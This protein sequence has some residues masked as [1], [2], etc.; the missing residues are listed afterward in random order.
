MVPSLILTNANV[1]TL[2]PIQPRAQAVAISGSWITAVGSRGEI[3]DLADGAAVVDLGG[4]TVVPGFNDAHVH[5]LSHGLQL[6]RV[7]LDGAASLEEALARVARAATAAKPGAW[8]LGGRWN[9]NVWP[10]PEF[11]TRF[12]L[13]AVSGDHPVALRNKD[14]HSLWANSQALARAGITKTTEQ[15][16]GGEITRDPKNG[17]PAGILKETAI[18]LVERVIPPPDRAEIREALK[19]A[20]R[21]AS[22]AGLTSV[23]AIDPPDSLSVLQDLLQAGELDLRVNMMLPRDRLDDAI[24]LGIQTGFGGPL[25]RLGCVKFIGDGALGS[26]TAAMLEPYVGQPDNRGILVIPP[27]ELA[28]CVR[29][30]AVAGISSAIHAIGDGANR[31]ALDAIERVRREGI[32]PELR[33]RIEHAQFVDPADLPRFAE[34]GVIA[35]VQPIHATSDRDMAERYWGERSRLAYRYRSLLESG[36]PLALG[37]DAPVEPIEPL[38]TVYAAVTRKRG[39]EP[40]GKPWYPEERLT[41]EQAI[42][43]YTLG[44]AYASGEERLKGS[45]EPGKLADLVVLSDD[46]FAVEPEAILKTRVEMTVFDGRIAE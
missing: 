43:A 21:Q 7:N 38:R 30:A 39:D 29:D 26:Q 20:M 34:L 23:H 18:R 9:K 45:I 27:D 12:D 44:S 1:R 32:G 6:G 14:G 28:E 41:M 33:H 37:T 35:S 31:V 11:P 17:E 40:L 5:L 3:E 46:V 10:R 22:R 15:P 16:A 36:A 2:N 8:I 25:L 42:H 24:R 19:A 4:S 13:D